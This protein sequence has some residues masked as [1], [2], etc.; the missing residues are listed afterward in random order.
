[1]KKRGSFL[2]LLLA[3]MVAMTG[4]AVSPSAVKGATTAINTANVG[5]DGSLPSGFTTEMWSMLKQVNKLRNSAGVQPLSGFPKL[6]DAAYKRSV[7][8]Q[9]KF[10]NERPGNK[11]YY[12]TIFNECGVSYKTENNMIDENRAKDCSSVDVAMNTIKQNANTKER[13]TRANFTNIGIGID[14]KGHYVQDLLQ[15]TGSITGIAVK[16]GTRKI[17]KG[18]NLSSLGMIIEVSDSVNGTCYLPLADYMCSGYKA[19]TDGEY[20]VKVSVQGKTTSFKLIVGSG[21]SADYND[22]IDNPTEVTKTIAVNQKV[23]LASLFEEEGTKYKI[24]KGSSYV[25]KDGKKLVGV[26]AGKAIITLFQKDGSGDYDAVEKVLVQV[27]KPKFTKKTITVSKSDDGTVDMN[28][29]LKN[30][31]DLAPTKWTVSNKKLATIDAESGELTLKKKGTLTVNAV[32]GSKS[33]AAKYS[34][35]VKIK[36]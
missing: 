13:L 3:G 12:Y 16:S 32:Y 29:Y 31:D 27:V 33:N 19:N 34:V 23:S 2:A 10:S 18:G 30:G 7:E 25:K 6:N 8:L 15:T 35:T 5:A 24:K 21:Q 26:K 17:A 9:K 1:M 36:K 20:T 28:E 4:F 11:G 22:D 14:G